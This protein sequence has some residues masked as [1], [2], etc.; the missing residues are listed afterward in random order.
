M[1]N[2]YTPYYTW[3]VIL[4]LIYILYL[5]IKLKGYREIII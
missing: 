3:G 4:N 1:K 2:D 5:N